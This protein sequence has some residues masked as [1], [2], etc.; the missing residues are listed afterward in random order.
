MTAETPD[1]IAAAAARYKR[2]NN[3]AKSSRKEL[4]DLVIEA[5]RQPG[6]EPV[7]IAKRAEWTPA[8]V[9][10]LAREKGI[11]ADPS[12]KARTEK[13]RARLLAEAASA[14]PQP[15]LAADAPRRRVTQAAPAP[16]RHK[17][18][19]PRDGR[20]LLEDEAKTLA[21]LAL[22]RANEM[23]GQKLRQITANAA[24]GYEDYA[25]VSSAL[26]IGLLAHDEVYGEPPGTSE[27]ATG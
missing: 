26:D 1:P 19:E 3:K 18:P 8:Y 4:S 7:D 27:E 16:K 20:P 12:Y 24:K 25:I 21:A 15:S 14:A 11:E 22:Q 17:G 5:L 13:A 2:D 23:Q 9:R 10:K 6:A